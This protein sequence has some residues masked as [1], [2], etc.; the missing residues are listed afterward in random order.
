MSQFYFGK[1]PHRVIYTNSGKES[2]EFI[3]V[4]ECS[5][6]LKIRR[7]TIIECCT[8]SA[9]GRTITKGKHTGK[10]FKYKYPSNAIKIQKKKLW[11]RYWE[12]KEN[13]LF[14]GLRQGAPAQP[15]R[16]RLF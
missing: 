9:F 1:T 4:L 10:H 5:K 3:S 13:K 14:V 2:K 7:A 16:L 15:L 11:S 6:E 8:S 12:W